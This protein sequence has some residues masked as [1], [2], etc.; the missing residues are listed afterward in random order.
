[1]EIGPDWDKLKEE[2]VE[3]GMKPVDITTY[4]SEDLQDVDFNLKD[5]REKRQEL[6]AKYL[7]TDWMNCLKKMKIMDYACN[8]DSTI[9]NSMYGITLSDSEKAELTSYATYNTIL[10]N[11]HEIFSERYQFAQVISFGALSEVSKYCIILIKRKST[12]Y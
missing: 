7:R 2:L 6:L 4:C 3:A 8:E 9:L 10:G 12:T 11:D 5:A 1:M